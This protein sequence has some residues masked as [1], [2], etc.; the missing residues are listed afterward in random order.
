LGEKGKQNDQKK[1]VKIA[2]WLYEYCQ[3][4]NYHSVH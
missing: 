4:T 1:K 2:A 3:S